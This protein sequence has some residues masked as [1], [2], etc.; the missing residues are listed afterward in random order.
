M[1]VYLKEDNIFKC[2]YNFRSLQPGVWQDSFEE[3]EGLGM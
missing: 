2:P 3:M 1:K